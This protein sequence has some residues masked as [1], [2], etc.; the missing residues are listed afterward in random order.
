MRVKYFTCG[1][2][3]DTQNIH[4]TIDL[5]ILG[6]HTM[7]LFGHGLEIDFLVDGLLLSVIL[8]TCINM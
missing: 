8:E 4:S 6:T 5:C 7:H 3:L 1:Y 2:P